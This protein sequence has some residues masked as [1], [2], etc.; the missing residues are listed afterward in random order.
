MRVS[1][2]IGLAILAAVVEP[3]RSEP[4]AMMV[5]ADGGGPPAFERV[6]W[7]GTVPPR[8]QFRY[9]LARQADGSFKVT[10]HWNRRRLG[11]IVLP[12]DVYPD[13]DPL[14]ARIEYGDRST[15]TLMLSYGDVPPDCYL[16]YDERDRFIITASPAK[17]L[18]IEN[19]PTAKSECE[20]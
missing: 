12:S 5:T 20:D 7:R 14:S 9:V 17:G 16:D 4:S 11:A 13:I 3:A 19:R 10:A 1:A 2:L 18:E 15:I 6:E 8:V